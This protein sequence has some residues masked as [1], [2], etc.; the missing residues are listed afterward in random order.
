MAARIPGGEKQAHI[1]LNVVILV[2]SC[3]SK[4]N[5][6][7][8]LACVPCPRFQFACPVDIA[9]GVS[10]F[11]TLSFPC[12]AFI[13]HFPT[14]KILE[15]QKRFKSIKFLDTELRHLRLPPLCSCRVS[16][17]R[18]LH[19]R[20]F[21]AVIS[22]RTIGRTFITVLLVRFLHMLN[23]FSAFSTQSRDFL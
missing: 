8:S 21:V 13:C 4:V 16:R 5:L 17:V 1:R 7:L 9:I 3:L 20:C 6:H 2:I 11:W 23:P 14:D 12:L 18:P 10:L 19:W 22:A 15:G